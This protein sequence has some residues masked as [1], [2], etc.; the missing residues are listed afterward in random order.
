M[1]IIDASSGTAGEASEDPIWDEHSLDSH[2]YVIL[3]ACIRM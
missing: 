3:C 1:G 2:D